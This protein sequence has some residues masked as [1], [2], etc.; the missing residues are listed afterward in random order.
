M[1]LSGHFLLYGI[2]IICW[3]GM[4][5]LLIRRKR[6]IVHTCS[7]VGQW[8]FSCW[9]MVLV[10]VIVLVVLIFDCNK[11]IRYYPYYLRQ[12]LRNLDMLLLMPIFFVGTVLCLMPLYFVKSKKNKEKPSATT[13]ASADSIYMEK[14][15][16][17]RF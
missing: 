5:L 6:K 12:G 11:L 15:T 3:W 9:R 13:S 14:L 16:K 8:R 10:A 4:A 2:G 7:C 1:S 17:F